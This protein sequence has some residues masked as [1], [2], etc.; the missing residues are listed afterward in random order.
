MQDK[1]FEK[2]ERSVSYNYDTSSFEDC[3]NKCIDG[4]Y[5]DPYQHKRIKCL[6]CANKRKQV[7]KETL[8]FDD[9]EETIADKLNLPRSYIGYGNYTIN[10]VL[11]ESSQKLMKKDSVNKVD[12]V[13]RDLINNISVGVVSE[14]SYLFNLGK[15]SFDNH[16]IYSYL[17]RAYME[18]LSVSPFITSYDLHIL[19][20]ES[21]MLKE[22]SLLAFRSLLK[23]DVCVV[24]IDAGASK[25]CINAVKG[26]MQLRAN[27]LKPTIIFTNA[28]NNWVKDLCVDEDISTYNLA[29]LV[30][31]EYD[32][33][34]LE[35][36]KKYEETIAQGKSIQSNTIG[37]DS[38]SFNKLL[39]P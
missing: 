35:K 31:I 23:T 13:L 9:S 19:R 10:G 34:Y 12:A 27:N 14:K 28:W 6:Y 2:E 26:F 22:D 33:K 7:V 24:S 37:M 36:E 11:P 39:A 30:S 17:V 21:E 16:F 5:V 25:Q 4:Y 20:L 15:K 38:T 3:P 8:V 32:E 18:G 29:T 1:I